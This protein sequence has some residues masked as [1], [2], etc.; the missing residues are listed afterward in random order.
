[1][2]ATKLLRFDLHSGRSGVPKHER[3]KRHF[4]DEM[5]AG[6]LKAGQAIPSAVQLSRT[7]GIAKMTVHQAMISLESEGLIRRVS[8]SGTYVEDNVRKKLKR[9]LDIFAL[10]VPQAHS[11]LYPS[12]LRGFQDA[13]SDVHHQTL[14]GNTDDSVERQDT[15]VLQ[16]LDKKVG[17]VAINPT[18]HE[19]TPAYQIRQLKDC[20]IPVVFIH[21]RVEGIAAPLLGIQQHKIARLTGKTLAEHGHKR[22]VLLG[23]LRASQTPTYVEGLREGLRVGGCDVPPQLVDMGAETTLALKEETLLAV[24]REVFASGD[25]PT[26][27]AT[28]FD[29][30]AEMVYIILPQLGLRVPEDVS[31]LGFGSTCRDGAIVQR[32][33]SVVIDEVATGRQA[34]SLLHEM[35]N[36]N[37]FINDNTEIVLDP[38]ISDGKTLAP[39]AQHN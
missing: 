32:L 37:R 30:V 22:V 35:R 3:I 36:G 39:A 6:R 25:R 1:M 18:G 5:L 10:L 8:G 19:P 9:G 24:L 28:T 12:L 20:G 2:E 23:S 29:S 31:L 13:A 16:L 34:V 33:T 14:I 17:G 38:S 15:I 26:A 7:L 4:V 21:H 27:V 11:G